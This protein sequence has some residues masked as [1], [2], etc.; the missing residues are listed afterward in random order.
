MSTTLVFDASAAVKWFRRNE[1]GA[2]ESAALLDSSESE[3]WLPDNG[4]HEVVNAVRLRRGAVL[5]SQCWSALEDAGVILGRADEQLVATALVVADELGCDYYDALAPALARLLGATLVS[6]D[7][8]AHGG[9]GDVV[10]VG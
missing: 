3:I 2:D 10:I 9:F 5:A 4:L 8:R 7:R 1:G 6:A